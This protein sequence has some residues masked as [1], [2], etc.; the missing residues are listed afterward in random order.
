MN[1][2]IDCSNLQAIRQGVFDVMPAGSLAAL[3][4]E[5]LRLL[6]CGTEQLCL[7]TLQAITTF[8]D[9]S[10]ATA[11]ALAKF[12]EWFWQVVENLSPKEKSVR[13]F[14]FNL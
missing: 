11:E 1:E 6:L 13:I 3:S 10:H 8:S 12:K 14:S 9:E 2:L 4:A 5:D 7:S